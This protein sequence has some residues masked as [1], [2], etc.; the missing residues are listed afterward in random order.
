MISGENDEIHKREYINDFYDENNH[1][2]FL[3]HNRTFLASINIGMMN[4]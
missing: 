2:E 4:Y 3:L 1:N